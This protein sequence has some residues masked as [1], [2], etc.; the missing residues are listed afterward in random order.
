MDRAVARLDREREAGDRLPGGDLDLD[1][2]VGV[3]PRE[4]A[5]IVA[6]RHGDLAGVESDDLE[7]AVGT[8][9][10]AFA[11][12]TVEPDRHQIV[13]RH[14][15]TDAHAGD[16][17]AI[18][19]DHAAGDRRTR[20]ERHDEVREVLGF[21][22]DRELAGASVA[23]RRD[24]REHAGWGVVERERAVRVAI[25]GDPVGLRGFHRI[26]DAD[27]AFLDLETERRDD[28]RI[29]ASRQRDAGGHLDDDAR[30]V[31]V[32]DLDALAHLGHHAF[33]HRE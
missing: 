31:L 23:V 5:L 33:P 32:G 1:G 17:S 12:A 22:V 10:D 13:L 7:R 3:R 26:A 15:R 8:G 30:D 19:V 6:H 25:A 16:R 29:D 27:L 2:L 9:D 21:D 24:D 20:L 14:R 4:L 11:H 18:R 28:G